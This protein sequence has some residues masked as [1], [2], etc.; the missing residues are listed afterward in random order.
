M[1]LENIQIESKFLEFTK[2]KNEVTEFLKKNRTYLVYQ[3]GQE[4]SEKTTRE[5]FYGE[6]PIQKSYDDKQIIG[7]YHDKSLIC[8]V[9]ILKNYPIQN[10]WVIGL[11]LLD[12]EKR[13]RGIGEKVYKQVEHY[14][15]KNEVEVIR[16]GVLE[17][18]T[19]G[20]RFWK[21]NGFTENGESKLHFDNRKIL[22]C[23]KIIQ[24]E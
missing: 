18:N 17:D 24:K 23:E 5:T 11:M 4:V 15:L 21:Q 1:S 20:K 22:V 13:G 12:E 10:T 8:I 6:L 3:D 16:L 19:I 2:D 9:D 7:F 14:L